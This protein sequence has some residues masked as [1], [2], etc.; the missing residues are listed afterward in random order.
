MELWLCARRALFTILLSLMLIVMT[1]LLPFPAFAATVTT[2]LDFSSMPTAS[3]A[4]DG[5]AWD[6][7]SLTLTLT[8]F[9]MQ[10][11]ST[12]QADP[13]LIL[14]GNATIVLQGDNT[15][16]LVEPNGYAVYEEYDGL[17]IEGPGTLNTTALNPLWVVGDLNII[18]GATVNA[19]SPNVNGGA[20]AIQANGYLT[21]NNA[22][23]NAT[24]CG[25]SCYPLDCFQTITIEGDDTVVNTNALGL[26]SF[27]ICGGDYSA[28]SYDP[29]IVITGGTVNVSSVS[30]DY[31]EGIFCLGPTTISG[32]VVNITASCTG[33]DSNE[34]TFTGGIT[35]VYTTLDPGAYAIAGYASITD[36]GMYAAQ[37][38][39]LNFNTPASVNYSDDLVYYIYTLAADSTTPATIVRVAPAPQQLLNYNEITFMDDSSVIATMPVANG[40]ALGVL[41]AAPEK[42]GYTFKG[43]YEQDAASASG[44]AQARA[45]AATL[46][47]AKTIPTADSTYFAQWTLATVTAP[48]APT[49]PLPAPRTTAPTQPVSPTTPH[50][51]RQAPVHLPET[52]DSSTPL[53]WLA[54]AGCAL[55]AEGALGVEFYRERHCKA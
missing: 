54:I 14:P 15:V 21:I 20:N 49:T 24:A 39:G 44:Q 3:N 38:D 10:Y 32:G 26:Y 16:D 27:G 28:Q 1:M 22:T 33:I 2:K 18:N 40:R 19:T 11:S 8:D 6:A 41:P 52:G 23:I 35:T 31:A 29:G 9:D 7:N 37:W 43:W 48:P 50:E 13:A 45:L 47:T 46:V 12:G 4:A 25:D 5:W 30:W 36:T 34:L 17:T 51:P 55:L 42:P 53:L